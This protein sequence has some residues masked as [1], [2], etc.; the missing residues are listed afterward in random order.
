M[1]PYS[2]A[3]RANADIDRVRQRVGKALEGGVLRKEDE[4]KYKRILATLRD[5]PGTAIYKVDQML[6]DLK[7]DIDIYQHEQR[8]AGRRAPQGAS[9]SGHTQTP[10]KVGDLVTVKGQKVRVTKLLP[11]GQYEAVAVP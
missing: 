11:N 5:T 3:A 10:Y 7:R 1:N 8:L 2:A 6:E 9:P 4:E